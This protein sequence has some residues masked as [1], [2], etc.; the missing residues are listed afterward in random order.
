MKLIGGTRGGV[1]RQ[2]VRPSPKEYKYTEK[3]NDLIIGIHKQTLDLYIVPTRFTF[4]WGKSVSIA[5]LD[6]LKWR[7]DLLLN[8]RD[9]YLEQV[10][11]ELYESR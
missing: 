7:F 11:R 8:W 1:D 5:H 3:H 4:N 10:Y 9:D 6:L 2:Y